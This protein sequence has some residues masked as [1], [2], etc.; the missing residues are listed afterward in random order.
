MTVRQLLA[1]TDSEE[2]TAW[3]GFE[4]IEPFGALMEEH[5][6]GQIA[7]AV[8]NSQRSKPESPVL[9]PSDFSP[10]L[11]RELQAAP[12]PEEERPQLDPHVEAQFLDAMFG[13]Q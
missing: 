5:R 13:F 2:L 1:S 9:T 8:F 7:A 3:M 6:S 11:R 10:A 12:E 4:R